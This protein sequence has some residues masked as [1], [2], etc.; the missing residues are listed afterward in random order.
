MY[1]MSYLV[2]AL[3]PDLF[4]FSKPAVPQRGDRQQINKIFKPD[5]S[6][7]ER[8]VIKLYDAM[9]EMAEK[10]RCTSA[11]AAGFCRALLA[12]LDERGNIDEAKLNAALNATI[13]R[14]E[15]E[16]TDVVRDCHRPAMFV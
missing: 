1:G 10:N 16:V 9:R 8:G 15:F 7:L 2:A 4:E 5:L 6:P 13:N 14:K 12:G 11:Q 3:F